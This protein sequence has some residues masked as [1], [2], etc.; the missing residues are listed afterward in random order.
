MQSKRS[1]NDEAATSVLVAKPHNE[2]RQSKPSRKETRDYI[3][4][5]AFEVPESLFGTPLATPRKRGIALLF[6]LSMVALLSGLSGN[7]LSVL[8]GILLIIAARRLKQRTQPRAMVTFLNVIGVF[9]VVISIMDFVADKSNFFGDSQVSKTTSGVIAGDGLSAL[10]F[11]TKYIVQVSNINEQLANKACESIF[12]CWQKV[13]L[14]MVDDMTHLNFADDTAEAV[15][16]GFVQASDDALSEQQ[17]A[18]LQQQLRVKYSE[19]S[20]TSE[21][22]T[23][24]AKV[25]EATGDINSDQNNDGNI[26]SSSH[27]QDTYADLE[28]QDESENQ[29]SIINLLKGIVADFGLGFGWAAFY[30]TAFTAL[31]HGQTLGKKLMGIKVIKLD[32]ST[33]STWESFGRYG[34]YG[35]GLATGLSGF[36]QIYW[37]ANRQAIQ[38]KISETLVIDLRR[39]KHTMTQEGELASQG[40]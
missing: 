4:P 11:S 24:S 35:A 21:Q 31:F 22:T 12:N 20:V 23:Q 40:L 17:K 39:P 10:A 37:D 3:T 8:I 13:G 1:V 34:G 27:Y 14:E 6:D 33:L 15:F 18:D 5:Y 19:L 26:I 29:Y 16:E 9:I 25:T 28:E 7:A 32:G 38:D 2:D 30:F 36:L